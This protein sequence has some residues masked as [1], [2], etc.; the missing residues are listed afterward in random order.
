[1]PSDWQRSYMPNYEKGNTLY[2]KMFSGHQPCQKAPFNKL[3]RLVAR[4]HFIVQSR[5]ESCKY[6]ATSWFVK[7][8][9]ESHFS[10]HYIN[11]PHVY[12]E[13]G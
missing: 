12:C 7:T 10:V 11:S 13:R 1:M 8:T 6:T 5:R 9:E 4:E 2:N 3:T